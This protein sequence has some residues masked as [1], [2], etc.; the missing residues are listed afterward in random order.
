MDDL[1]AR[2][3]NGVIGGNTTIATPFGPKPLVYAD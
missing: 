3:R 1:L 2:I